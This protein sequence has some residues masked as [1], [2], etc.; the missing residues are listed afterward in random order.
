[1]AKWFDKYSFNARYV[2]AFITAIPAIVFSAFIKRDV[3]ISLFENSNFLITENLSLSVI[4]ILFI[5]H[6]QRGIAKHLFENRIFK[7]GKEFPTTTM[8]LLTNS[9]LSVEMKNKIR[10]KIETDFGIRLCT[11]EQEQVNIEEAKKTIRDAVNLIRK[12]VKDGDKTLQYNIHYGLSRNLI[13][14]AIFAVPI[15][16]LNSV[17]FGLQ[18]QPGFYLSITM[19]V[20]FSI[21]LI[22]SKNILIHYANAYAEYLLSEFLTTKEKGVN[23]D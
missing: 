7:S 14:G 19:A 23:H 18:N 16:V 21:T 1:M 15:S 3:W 2:P 6:V 22:F 13:A 10:R 9:F 20:F 8:L 12:Q 4:T 11:L 5:I 17:L